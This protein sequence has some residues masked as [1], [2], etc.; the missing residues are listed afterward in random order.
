MDS[1][2]QKYQAASQQEMDYIEKV[3]QAFSNKCEELKTQT[4]QKIA[5]LDT[6]DPDFKNKENQLK[7]ELKRALD[8]MVDEYEKEVKKSFRLSIVGLEEIYHQK[9]LMRLQEIEKEILNY[10]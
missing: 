4:E 10:K 9:E 3:T 2:S 7:L 6:K 5:A 8:K 1:V